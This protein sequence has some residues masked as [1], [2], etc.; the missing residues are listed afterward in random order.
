MKE[1]RHVTFLV[2]KERKDVLLSIIL[3]F[4]AGISAV[5]LFASSGYLIS[6]GALVPPIYTLT[7]MIALLKLF[8]FARAFSRYGERYFSHRATFTILS[9]LRVSFYKKIEPLAPRI[10]QKYRSGDLLARIVGDVESLQNFFLR[11]F[12][13][14][15]VLVIVFLS[16]IL[17]ISYFSVILAFVMLLGLLL[18]GFVVPAIFALDQRKLQRNVREGR[19]RLSTEVTELFYGFRDLKIYQQ[20]EEKEKLLTEVAGD[21][22]VEQETEG[23]QEIFNHS[24]NTF[25]TLLVSWLILALGAY[26]TVQGQFEGL[27]LA[28]LVMI[29]LTVFENAAPMAVFP[30]HYE[31]SR[32]AAGRLEEVVENEVVEYVSEATNVLPDNEA[33]SFHMKDVSFTFPGESSSTLANVNVSFESGTKTAIVGPSGSGKS[34][35]LYLLLKLH[36]PDNGTFTL[37]NWNYSSVSSEDLWSKSNVVLQENHYFYGTIRENLAI[38]KEDIK[39]EEM[40]EALGMVKLNHFSLE[41]RV[42]EKG[43][44]LSGGEKQRLAIARAFL[45]GQHV[46]LLDEPTSSVDA[47]TENA[48]FEKLFEKAKDDTLVLVSHRLTGLERMDQ[49]IVM[50]NGNVV[51]AGTFDEL[52]KAKGYFYEMKEIEKSVFM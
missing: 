29:S 46:W 12:Y 36:Q 40:L 4:S 8:G 7:V 25:V 14:P 51:E 28:M 44:N 50:E 9:N 24:V 17:F 48:I 23:K 52:M 33:L 35:L 34:T 15:V 3:G 43:E 19:A 22:V 18:T 47:V 2:M 27:F 37:N 39:D 41:D 1:L 45:K 38:A 30:N 20:L 13:P 5:G 26:L 10:F 49:I 32:R 16:T 31:D 6:K 42:L 11:V 21:Y